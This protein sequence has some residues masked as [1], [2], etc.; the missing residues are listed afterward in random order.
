MMT[1]SK[2]LATLNSTGHL[3]AL[4]IVISSQTRSQK[5]LDPLLGTMDS[6]VQ[7]FSTKILENCVLIFTRWKYNNGQR[8][9]QP[10]ELGTLHI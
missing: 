10:Y 4:L 8:P 2:L 1:F 6:L 9:N 5:D 7:L 3:D